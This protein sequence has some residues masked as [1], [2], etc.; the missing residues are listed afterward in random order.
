VSE[1]APLRSIPE[2][3]VPKTVRDA[4]EPL[5]SPSAGFF[6]VH[7]GDARRL[8]LILS[9][10]SSKRKPLLTATVTSP[11]YGALK[12][13]GHPEQ[14][15]WG[16]PHDEYRVELRRVFR[17]I[18]THTKSNGA[19]WVVADTLRQESQEG[20]VWPIQPLPFELAEEAKH[21]GWILREIIIWLKDKTLPWSSRGR[22]RNE[23]EYVLFFVKSDKFKYRVDRLRQPSDLEQWWVRYPERYNPQG[24]APTNVW[25][26]P[27][28]VQG[29]WANT[30]IQ[31]ACPLPAD[32]I[33]RMLLISTDPGDVVLDPF[34]GSGV[35]V[36]E[37]QRLKRRGLGV[38]LIQEHIDAFHATVLP[39]ITERRGRDLVQELNSQSEQLR[40]TILDLRAVK[41]PKKLEL[42]AR[43]VDPGLARAEALYCF[44][45]GGSKK[46]LDLEII[47]VLSDEDMEHADSW[48]SALSR[49]TRRRPV[50]K[51][52]VKPRL[53]IIA[54]SGQ[55]QLHRGRRLWAYV[56]G[57][58]HQAA[59]RCTSANVAEFQAKPSRHGLPLIVSNVY[60]D[61]NPRR[62]RA[63]DQVTE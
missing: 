45:R 47:V 10:Y 63:A 32:L 9:Q 62:L 55:K 52:G 30:T 33:E 57:R 29:S 11:P 13:Y 18:Y 51:F 39:E 54:K 59:G 7:Q 20:T 43:E 40:R 26:V 37:A 48:L 25:Q 6:T 49:A 31:H 34:A 42:K 17:S 4:G 27:I 24:K 53:H 5:I 19:L 50:S 1:V 28:P 60:V 8:D 36:A 41:Y 22:M 23:F 3:P 56:G 14:I 44:R 38:E 58:T 16:Q 21:E 2:P 46:Y 15:G 61:E 12:D 35:V